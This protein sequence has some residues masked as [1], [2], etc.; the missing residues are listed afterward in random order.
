MK[1][2]LTFDVNGKTDTPTGITTVLM[3]G[4]QVKVVLKCNGVWIANGKFGCTFGGQNR[5]E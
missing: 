4:T 1:R 5:F 3:K 2:R